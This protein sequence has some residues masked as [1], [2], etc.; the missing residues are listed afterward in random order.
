MAND[1]PK[2]GNIIELP[3]QQ[4]DHINDLYRRVLSLEQLLMQLDNTVATFS[5]GVSLTIEAM[6]KLLVSKGIFT[7][8]E[9]ENIISELADLAREDFMKRIESMVNEVSQ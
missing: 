6:R 1:K 8:E 3:G 5:L 9:L 2:E 7:Q 4:R